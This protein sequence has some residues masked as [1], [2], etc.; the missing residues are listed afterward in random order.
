ML[1]LL[2]A[3]R[4]SNKKMKQAIITLRSSCSNPPVDGINRLKFMRGREEFYEIFQEL[5]LKRVVISDGN[6]TRMK[7]SLNLLILVDNMRKFRLEETERTIRSL[8]NALEKKQKEFSGIAQELKE[9]KLSLIGLSKDIRAYKKKQEDA[10]NFALAT[11]QEKETEVRC[12]SKKME[13]QAERLKGQE[14]TIKMLKQRET[15]GCTF[16]VRRCISLVDCTFPVRNRVFPY[17]RGKIQCIFPVRI[18]IFP[19]RI[20]IFPM[21]QGKYQYFPYQTGKILVYSPQEQVF[22]RQIVYFKHG[23]YYLFS[24]IWQYSMSRNGSIVR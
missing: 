12:L 10:I 8:S 3:V 5:M 6:L 1:K 2:N 4:S 21:R 16:T 19:V 7:D 23:I 15:K 22:D 13:E 20:S 17:Q 18:S 11:F 14:S 24:S 9:H